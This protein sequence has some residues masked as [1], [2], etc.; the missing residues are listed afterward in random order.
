MLNEAPPLPLC[1]TATHCRQPLQQQGRETFF[2]STAFT[3]F[4]LDR[5]DGQPSQPWTQ[6][7]QQAVAGA[8]APLANA[9]VRAAMQ[10]QPQQQQP[11]ASQLASQ[12]TVVYHTHPV[13]QVP[14][15]PGAIAETRSALLP[16]SR[17][18]SVDPAAAHLAAPA[19]QQQALPLSNS[20]SGAARTAQQTVEVC[21]CRLCV[22]L[23]RAHAFSGPS[24][25][26]ACGLALQWMQQMK[27]ELRKHGIDIKDKAINPVLKHCLKEGM[28]VL[29]AT[30]IIVAK[31]KD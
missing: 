17:Q 19:L 27:R 13:S 29:T 4:S 20:Q 25:L 12:A 21:V 16:P 22:L 6:V 30:A 10:H 15:Q 1:L 26:T 8:S 23:C 9:G 14:S 3:A 2:Y 28:P 24:E 7:Q 18:P 11:S 5:I 31:H